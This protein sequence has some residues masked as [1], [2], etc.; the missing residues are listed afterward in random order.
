M[1]AAR[2]PAPHRVLNIGYQRA[3]PLAALIECIERA[4]GCTAQ[5]RMR[6]MQDSDVADTCADVQQLTALTG[7]TPRTPLALGVERLVAWYRGWRGEGR[8][9][10]VP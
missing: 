7:L 10:A 2:A 1:P 5:R 9:A 6:P 8:P 4:T 3:E